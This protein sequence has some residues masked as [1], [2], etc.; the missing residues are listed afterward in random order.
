M[1]NLLTL[2]DPRVAY[3]EVHSFY[4]NLSV[5]RYQR[6]SIDV[7]LSPNIIFYI[8]DR[9]LKFE[10]FIEIFTFFLF[11]L[12][13][14]LIRLLYALFC[15]LLRIDIHDHI[16]LSEIYL[17]L[18]LEFSRALWILRIPSSFNREH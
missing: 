5:Q 17:Y 7:P 10:L 3:L 14:E 6:H 4:F 2:S 9:W 1:D 18:G 8:Y 11:L 13:P 15:R 16:F 12:G